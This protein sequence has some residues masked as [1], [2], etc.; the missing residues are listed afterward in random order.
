MKS[1]LVS[2]LIF[3]LASHSIH[4][5][6]TLS[7]EVVDSATG[8]PIPYVNVGVVKKGIGTVTD[9]NGFLSL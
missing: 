4:G 6:Y 9:E 1:I 7:S 3:F 8:K 5:Q 2:C